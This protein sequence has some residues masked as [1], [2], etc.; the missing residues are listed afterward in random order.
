MKR[1]IYLIMA[2]LLTTFFTACLSPVKTTPITRYDIEPEINVTAVEPSTYTLGVR[3]LEAARPYRQRIVYREAG[4]VLGEHQK[5]EWAELPADSF[6]LALIEAITT[7]AKFSDIGNASNMNAPDFLL[8]GQL[9][10][11]DEDRTSEPWAAVVEVRLAL[12]PTFGAGDI[13]SDVVTAKIP[14][15]KNEV[16][17]LPAAMSKAVADVVT[18]VANEIAAQPLHNTHHEN[19]SSEENAK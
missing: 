10:R 7:T 4:Y 1:L 19:E 3:T 12:R 11:F 18:E 15:E 9:R 5:A 14:L 2:I 6:T 17:A 8:T 13:W 16:T